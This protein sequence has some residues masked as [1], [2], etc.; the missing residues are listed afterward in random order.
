MEFVFRLELKLM[1]MVKPGASW[2]F[3]NI[4]FSGIA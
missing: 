1:S 4:V 3:F 2:Y